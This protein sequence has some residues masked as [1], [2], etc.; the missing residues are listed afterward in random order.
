[1]VI[2]LLCGPIPLLCLLHSDTFAGNVARPVAAPAQPASR[3]HAPKKTCRPISMSLPS[4][5]LKEA[6]LPP[7]QGRDS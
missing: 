6:T 1:M 3:V 5:S 7:I 2:S 4:L